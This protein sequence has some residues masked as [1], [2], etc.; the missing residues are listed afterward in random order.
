MMTLEPLDD[1]V[2]VEVDTDST[3]EVTSGGIYL[4]ESAKEKPR[5]GT[6]VA[7]GT[8]EGL[9]GKVKVGDRILYGK[10]SGDEV[11]L[12]RKTVILLQ[13][14]EILALVRE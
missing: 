14:N 2:L 10:Y 1:R 3:P 6:V 12:N 9:R 8:D 11:V 4:P 7:V 13:R 5:I